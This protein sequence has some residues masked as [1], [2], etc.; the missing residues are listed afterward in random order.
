MSRVYKRGDVSDVYWAD[1]RDAKGKRVRK[2][3][4]CKDQRAALATLG[5]WE[6]E[7][8][9]ERV[10]IM[11]IN[12]EHLR[13]PLETHVEEWLLTLAGDGCDARYIKH[14]RRE[15]SVMRTRFAWRTLADL[16]P[17]ALDAALYE[18]RSETT[19]KTANNKRGYLTS[20][21]AWCVRRRRLI[22]N[23]CTT[24][25][26]ECNDST[27]RR[28]MKLEEIHKLLTCIEIPLWRRLV[29]RVLI[30]TGLRRNE[31]RGLLIEYV[32]LDSVHAHLYIPASLAKSG[33]DE[34]I[35]LND[36]MRRLFKRATTGRDAADA[37]FPKVPIAR[38]FQMDLELA[39]IERTDHRGRVASLHSTRHTMVSLLG[40]AGAS[41]PDIMQVAR[42]RSIEQ[43]R[44]YLDDALLGPA[45]TMARLPSLLPHTLPP[46]RVSDGVTPIPA[47]PE[48]AGESCAVPMSRHTPV[49]GVL[50]DEC[51]RQELNLSAS[52]RKTDAFWAECP[53][54]VPYGVPR[55]WSVADSPEGVARVL[56]ELRTGTAACYMRGGR[57]CVIEIPKEPT[58]VAVPDVLPGD[59]DGADSVGS[60]PSRP[61]GRGADVAEG[62]APTHEGVLG[63]DCVRTARGDHYASAVLASPDV[64]AGVAGPKDASLISDPG[65]NG[66][67]AGSTTGKSLGTT[68]ETSGE[69]G[70]PHNGEHFTPAPGR[71]A[72]TTDRDFQ[73]TP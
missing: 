3:T 11:P 40:A 49:E 18:L 15:L 51:R 12:V 8:E 60:V 54:G 47:A 64:A 57:L 55:P 27:K 29:Y 31:A 53:A 45:A 14:A 16:T 69:E 37:V 20:L 52:P 66:E 6:Q 46:I 65:V 9:L 38:R 5:K 30:G 71:E 68:P 25:P 63:V 48:R 61:W 7:A 41:L 4:Q 56:H 1:Y 33:E 10:G 67:C 28:A 17:E 21:L 13:A 50:L 70:A 42:H 26:F 58:H 19:A 36:E 44:E 2:S 22:N 39:K 35:P 24:A 72:P 59:R 32:R 23:P 73:E 34:T 62:S 43:T